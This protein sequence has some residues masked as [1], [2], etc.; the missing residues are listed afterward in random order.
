MTATI[1][2]FG[3]MAQIGNVGLYLPDTSILIDF[4]RDLTIRAKLEHTQRTGSAFVI[5]P[6]VLAELVRG[7][8]AG[9]PDLFVENKE[10]IIWLHAQNC[11]TLELP[12]PFMA[13]ILRSSAGKK[14]GVAPEH[15]QRLIEMVVSSTDFADF[16]NR[17]EKPGSVRGGIAQAHKIHEGILDRELSALVTM[18]EEGRDKDLPRL[19][20]QTLGVPGCRPNPL[21]LQKHFSAALEFLVLLR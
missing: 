2:S 10:V 19:L 4:G 8:I 7:M 13:M 12:R 17:A 9:G 14:S 3:N 5:G 15:F 18:A 11:K 6:P 1:R 16:P 20:S 21:I